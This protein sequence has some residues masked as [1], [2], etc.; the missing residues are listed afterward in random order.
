MAYHQ[1]NGVEYWG[2]ENA[3]SSYTMEF[4]DKTREQTQHPTSS[5]GMTVM[6]SNVTM[7][8]TDETAEQTRHPT[9]S[10]GMTDMRSNI[11]IEFT[12]ETTEQTLWQL[13]RTQLQVLICLRW[14]KF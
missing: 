9:S 2:M 8:F 14:Q 11:T 12:D 10:P 13:I 3:T 1:V 5:P 4:T 6:R 7:E